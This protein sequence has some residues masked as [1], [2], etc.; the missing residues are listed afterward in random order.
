MILLRR[1]IEGWF[2]SKMKL[3][4]FSWI[5]KDLANALQKDAICDTEIMYSELS[6]NSKRQEISQ[7]H[8][9]SVDDLEYIYKVANLT[10]IRWVSPNVARILVD[11]GYE[12]PEK[13]ANANYIELGKEFAEHNNKAQYFK[14]KIGDR[15][16][17]RLINEA[18]YVD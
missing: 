13:I 14:G 11:I 12:S 16:I 4:Q 7:K 8:S 9:I 15:D 3:E 10:R 17:K 2:A 5:N 6:T 1:E 18:K